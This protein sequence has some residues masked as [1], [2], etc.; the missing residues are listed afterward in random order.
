MFGGFDFIRQKFKNIL[1]T[2]DFWRVFNYSMKDEFTF[3]V[4]RMF[5]RRN[6]AP[7][8]IPVVTDEGTRPSGGS[9]H[10]GFIFFSKV[11]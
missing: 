5:C 2:V 7:L 6:A 8:N 11:S 10:G 3:E 1:K 4:H 9:S